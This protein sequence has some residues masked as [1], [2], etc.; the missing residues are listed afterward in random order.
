MWVKHNVMLKVIGNGRGTKFTLETWVHF[1]K[2]NGTKLKFNITFHPQIEINEKGQWA[3][4]L[5]LLEIFV[6]QL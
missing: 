2:K 4:K 3:I 6:S 5:I 1:M